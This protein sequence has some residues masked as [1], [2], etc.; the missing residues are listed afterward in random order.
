VNFETWLVL[1]TSD[2]TE[3]CLPTAITS[4]APITAL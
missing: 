2:T 3:R 4:I 1:D